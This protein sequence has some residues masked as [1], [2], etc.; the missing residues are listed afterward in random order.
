MRRI[1]RFIV[2]IIVLNWIIGALISIYQHIS[3]NDFKCAEIAQIDTL[4]YDVDHQRLWSD[5]GSNYYC[6][7][8]PF[9]SILWVKLD[10]N[11]TYTFEE[12]HLR[13]NLHVM[14]KKT[15]QRIL[16]T[17]FNKIYALYLSVTVTYL[18]EKEKS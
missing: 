2:L 6:M 10:K 7:A 1:L 14:L 12:N 17:I 11:I 18:I 9:G 16:I 4:T 8:Y 15:R 5:L 13:L 3:S